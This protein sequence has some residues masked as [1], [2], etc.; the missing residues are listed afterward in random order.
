MNKYLAILLICIPSFI[1][2]QSLGPERIERLN[3]SVVRIL[4]ETTPYGTGFFV[5]DSGWVATCYHVIEPAFI[6]DKETNR[7]TG[8]KKIYIEFRNGEK[9][10]MGIMNYL[11]NKGYK[12][13]SAYDYL[14]LKVQSKPKTKY[15]KL[16][17]GSWS[18]DINEGD[19]VYSCGYPLG[20]KQRFISQGLFST[21]WT[22]TI[23]RK[24]LNVVTDTYTRKVAW[25]DL[26]MNKGNSGGPIIKLGKSPD[27]DRVIGIATFILNPYAN[28][29]ALLSEY[30]TN[31]RG[32]DIIA[33]GVSSNKISALF[34]RAIA[35][36][37]IG[38][39]G[40]ISIEYINETLRLMNH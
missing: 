17:I 28:E 39:S 36:N 19:I 33:N 10:Q 32:I 25:L 15:K 37:S 24:V 14:L 29:A 11:L 4:I 13:A 8:L 1:F 20:R 7:V 27:E 18:S 12:K 16:K 21:K 2:S 5:H 23:E 30:L 22:D 31:G 3:K 6:R 40:C 26:T 34:A 9:I 38:V 35:N